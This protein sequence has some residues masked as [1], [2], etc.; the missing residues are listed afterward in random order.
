MN[1]ASFTD[2]KTENER[3]KKQNGSIDFEFNR[4]VNDEETDTESTL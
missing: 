2:F 4:G 3:L 1:N